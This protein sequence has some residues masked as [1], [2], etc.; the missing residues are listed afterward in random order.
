MGS[1]AQ[2]RA[3]ASKVWVWFVSVRVELTHGEGLSL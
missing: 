2:E 1:G 3:V